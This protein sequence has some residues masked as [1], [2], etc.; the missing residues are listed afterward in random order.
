MVDVLICFAA[1]PSSTDGPTCR[2]VLVPATGSRAVLRLEQLWHPCAVASA[3]GTGSIVPNDLVLGDECAPCSG[4]WSDQ[5]AIG[6]LMAPMWVVM[7]QT[8]TR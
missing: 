8:H 2:P 3:G 6:E 5:K 4:G 7:T 1:F